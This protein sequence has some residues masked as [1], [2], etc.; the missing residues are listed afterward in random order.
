MAWANRTENPNLPFQCECISIF[1]KIGAIPNFPIAALTTF[2]ETEWKLVGKDDFS[3][4]KDFLLQL[5]IIP[6][7]TA[8]T[9]IFILNPC[10]SPAGLYQQRARL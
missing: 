6:V 5:V 8:I 4:K 2:F 10:G 3:E 9:I 1:I 7:I